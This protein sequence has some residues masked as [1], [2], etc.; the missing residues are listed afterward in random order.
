MIGALD[1]HI[2]AKE[3]AQELRDTR[4]KACLSQV[5]MAKVLGVSRRTIG[6]WES[7]HGRLHKVY[8]QRIRQM[9]Q[10]GT[11]AVEVPASGGP[12]HEERLP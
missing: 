3:V 11:T 7:G 9:A 1:M 4:L 12:T 5:A 10:N 2:A 6:R 8:L